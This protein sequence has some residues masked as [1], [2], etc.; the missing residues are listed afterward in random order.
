[1]S[2]KNTNARK[3]VCERFARLRALLRQKDDLI[4]QHDLARK[5]SE[6]RLLNDLQI[7]ASLLALQGRAS[8]NAV[9]VW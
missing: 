3:S 1:M 5:E 9:V 8:G 4:E 6:H 2:A 7:V